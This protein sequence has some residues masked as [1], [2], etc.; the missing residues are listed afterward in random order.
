MLTRLLALASALAILC[1]VVTGA[2]AAHLCSMMQAPDEEECCCP[3]DQSEERGDEATAPGDE[4]SRAGCCELR[5]ADH[6]ML[7]VPAGSLETGPALAAA[8]AQPGRV[9]LP[10]RHSGATF[11][12]PAP[13]W[14]GGPPLYIQKCSYLI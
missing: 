12:G 10:Q 1:G 2:H 13:P 5:P 6:T 9:E 11:H 3:H 7:P 4:L 14:P 8:P